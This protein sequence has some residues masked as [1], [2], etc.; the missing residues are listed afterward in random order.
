VKNVLFGLIAIA[1]MTQQT[2][3]RAQP[4]AADTEVYLGDLAAAQASRKTGAVADLTL[5]NISNNPGYNNQPSFTPDGRAVLF[6][7]NRDGK[8]TDIYR[9]DI[10]SKALTQLTHTTESEYSPLVTPDGKG[11]SVIRVEADKTQRLWRFDLDGTNPRLVLE[12][13]KQVGYHVWIDDHRLALFVVGTQGQPSTLQLADT[14]TGTAVV[15]DRNIGR[16]LLKRP[17][18]NTISYVS[19][20]TTPWMVKEFDPDTKEIR[21]LTPVVNGSEDC[22]WQTGSRLLMAHDAKIFLWDK[23]GTAWTETGDFSS[24]GVKNITRLAVTRFGQPVFAFV[25]EPVK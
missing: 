11:F 8:Q 1:A 18:G 3:Q 21:D 6:S 9:Y 17:G 15:I 20:Q 24:S 16:S 13:I 12:N 14:T 25:A 5:V 19:K 10:A 23:T 7:S 22:A 4:P 2:P